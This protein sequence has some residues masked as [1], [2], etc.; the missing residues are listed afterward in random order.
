MCS[1]YKH[2]SHLLNYTFTV[3]KFI[4]LFIQ[5]LLLHTEVSF[6]RFPVHAFLVRHLKQIAVCNSFHFLLW[7]YWEDYIQFNQ[8]SIF[9]VIVSEIS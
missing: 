1:G 2:G 8:D 7:I 4:G 9:D 6:I 3:L 5:L